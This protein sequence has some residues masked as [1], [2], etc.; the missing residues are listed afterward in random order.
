MSS[1][2]GVTNQAGAE[3]LRRRGRMS[4]PGFQDVFRFMFFF[5]VAEVGQQREEFRLLPP[6]LV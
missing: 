6:P 1:L 2:L 5:V 3:R 4:I